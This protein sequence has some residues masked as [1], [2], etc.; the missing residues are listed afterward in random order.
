MKPEIIAVLF[1]ATT[2]ESG[3]QFVV[4]SKVREALEL[5]EDRD[6]I[7]LRIHTPGGGS[8]SVVKPL[9]SGPEIY[10]PDIR[11]HVKA[12]DRILVEASRPASRLFRPE[13]A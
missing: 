11:A 2:H 7:E 13:A 12:G 1:A 5:T 9:M 4:P 8:L 10:G 6:E 3:D